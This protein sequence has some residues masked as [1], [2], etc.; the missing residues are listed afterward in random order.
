MYAKKFNLLCAR[1]KFFLTYQ[2]QGRVLTPTPLRTPLQDRVWQA[3]NMGS[4][5]QNR[6]QKVFNRGLCGSAE[7]LDIIK[8]TKT[9]LI[10]S[11]SRVNLGKLGVLLGGVSSPRPPPVATGLTRSHVWHVT[12]I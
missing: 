6:R 3:R 4:Q 8:L 9:P 7:G 12:P 10:Y 1:N 11:V 2:T 5:K